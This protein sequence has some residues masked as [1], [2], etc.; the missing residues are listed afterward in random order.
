MIKLS[1]TAYIYQGPNTV[2]VPQSMPSQ[3]Q[4]LP[5]RRASAFG[6]AIRVLNGSLT[7]RVLTLLP[8]PQA[9]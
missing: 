8:L 4:G 2:P 6:A 1:V 9:L 7:Y 3:R 5:R